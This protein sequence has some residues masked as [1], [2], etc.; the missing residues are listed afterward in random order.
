MAQIRIAEL[1]SFCDL[2]TSRVPIAPTEVTHGEPYLRTRRT[3]PMYY[4]RHGFPVPGSEGDEEG[5]LAWARLREK[6]DPH[7]ACDELPDGSYL[8]TVW[9]GLDHAFF[10]P[11]LIFETMRYKDTTRRDPLV[12][13]GMLRD[14]LEFPDPYDPDGGETDQLRYRTEEEA[15][16]AH[17]EIVRCLRI[18]LGC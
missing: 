8:S 5:T 6:G 1:F 10:G 4:D 11:P 14:W 2:H 16:A 13:Q 9:L 12:P 18:R 7:V 3:R 15:A 17:H